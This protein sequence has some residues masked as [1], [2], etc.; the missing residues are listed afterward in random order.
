[1]LHNF[2]QKTYCN[3]NYFPPILTPMRQFDII[4]LT[5]CRIPYLYCSLSDTEDSPLGSTLIT[6]LLI[7]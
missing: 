5:A 7:A 6:G 4:I 3:I 1:M 2:S